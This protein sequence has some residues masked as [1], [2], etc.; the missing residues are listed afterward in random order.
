MKLFASM[1]VAGGLVLG[2]TVVSAQAE[3]EI[4]WAFGCKLDAPAVVVT[5]E[6]VATLEEQ[7]GGYLSWNFDA[8]ESVASAE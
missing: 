4:S 2:S 7:P 5:E 3:E 6:Q 8:R 1:A